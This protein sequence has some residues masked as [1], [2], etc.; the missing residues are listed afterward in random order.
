MPV[1]LGVLQL[2]SRLFFGHPQ[3]K[4]FAPPQKKE[5]EGGKR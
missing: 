3:H 5:E 2:S 4:R 1:C